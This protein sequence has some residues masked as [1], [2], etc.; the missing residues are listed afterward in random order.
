MRSQKEIEA[1]ITRCQTIVAEARRQ[2]KIQKEIHDNAKL[3]GRDSAVK[4]ASEQ[5]RILGRQIRTYNRD[6]LCFQWVLNGDSIA[7]AVVKKRG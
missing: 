3:D 1:E 6:I 2:E 7:G 5:L 4:A